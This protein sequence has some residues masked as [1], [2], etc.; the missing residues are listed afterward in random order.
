[1]RERAIRAPRLA[2]PTL[3]ASKAWL[4][5]SPIRLQVGMEKAQRSST[6]VIRSMLGH[7]GLQLLR[8]LSEDSS[9]GD[10][11]TSDYGEPERRADRTVTVAG[12]IRHSV[13]LTNPASETISTRAYETINLQFNEHNEPLTVTSNGREGFSVTDGDL[14]V[15]FSG[16]ENIDRM[17]AVEGWDSTA[18]YSAVESNTTLPAETY[19]SA[20]VTGGKALFTSRD[21]DL[22]YVSAAFTLKPGESYEF[23]YGETLFAAEDDPSIFVNYVD[24]VGNVLS[25]EAQV[26]CGRVGTS[27]T[28][29]D[30]VLA[31]P[32]GYSIAQSFALPQSV[33]Y[34]RDGVKTIVEISVV[35][36][37]AAADMITVK[38]DTQ[39]GTPETIAD[40]KLAA[41]GMLSLPA[42]PSQTSAAFAGWARDAQG[43]AAFDPDT[44]IES[45]LT[46]YAQRAVIDDGTHSTPLEVPEPVTSIADLGPRPLAA[47]G[48]T[49]PVWAYS[50]GALLLVVGTV[51]AIARR[52]QDNG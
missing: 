16:V 40:V 3:A 27:L 18:A 21:V 35:V 19:E 10:V 28:L 50:L 20:G 38:F 1:M 8:G 14:T 7:T 30:E 39:G 9:R 42:A 12:E 45:S 15:D 31:A 36:T 37:P 47:T 4:A 23:S 26:F 5:T 34:G 25:D 43:S 49:S 44:A 13:K 29:S 22:T 48:S 46:L 41:G 6:A 24:E 17:I 32:T 52:G 11:L 51:F 2:L 33:A